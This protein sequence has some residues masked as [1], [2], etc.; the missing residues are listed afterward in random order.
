M[1]GK[2]VLSPCLFAFYVNDIIIKV[3]SCG[4]G[5]HLGFACVN[6]ILYADD[7]LLPTPSI[8]SLQ[9]L[10]YI[11]KSELDSIDMIINASKSN[12]LRIGLNWNCNVTNVTLADRNGASIELANGCR[13][14]GFFMTSDATFTCKFYAA[15]AKLYRSF[16]AIMGRAG[17]C[18]SLE[19]LFS[20]MRSK[21]VPALLYGIE[22][23]PVNITETR[24]LEYPITCAFFKIL[25][26]HLPTWLISVV[27]LVA[28]DNF[29]ISSL[30]R[31]IASMRNMSR[32][33]I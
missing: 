19:V 3:T 22:A 29:L 20:L 32:R 15:K 27:L 6:I 26:P 31:K 14:L 24:S 28:L 13:Y 11:C 16:N 21:C 25:K 30:I 10:L 18:V 4:I 2:E 1:F 33:T 23:C 5:C 9:S 12:C 7:I 8:L 17:S